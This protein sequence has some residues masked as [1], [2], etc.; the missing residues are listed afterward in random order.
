MKRN[1]KNDKIKNKGSKKMKKKKEVKEIKVNIGD[2]NK[3][4]ESDSNKNIPTNFISLSSVFY[5]FLYLVQ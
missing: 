2:L 4:K 3:S 5:I 1:S